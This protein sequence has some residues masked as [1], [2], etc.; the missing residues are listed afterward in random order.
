MDPLHRVNIGRTARMI[1]NLTP[2]GRKIVI[3]VESIPV[4]Y[5]EMLADW[6]KNLSKNT[7]DM[8]REFKRIEKQLKEIF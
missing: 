7:I 6:L 5:L 8:E 3:L 4:V 1:L 2:Q